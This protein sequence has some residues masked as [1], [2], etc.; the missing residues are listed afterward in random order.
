DVAVFHSDGVG[1]RGMSIFRNHREL[2]GV[3]KVVGSA[4]IG[5]VFAVVSNLVAVAHHHIGVGGDV[6]HRSQA[7]DFRGQ[8]QSDSHVVANGSGGHAVD[9]HAV[10]NC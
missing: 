3:H 8:R 2:T 1:V 9:G 6:E 10:Q 7:G 5:H 4:G